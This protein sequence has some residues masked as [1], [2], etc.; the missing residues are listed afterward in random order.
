LSPTIITL[1]TLAIGA[2][3][4]LLAYLAGFPVPALTGPSII[5]CAVSLAG[6]KTDISMRVRDLSFVTIGIGM[7]T[8][9]TP[10]V[11]D[12]ARD[13][14]A[15]FVAL[16]ATLLLMFIT[17]IQIL[18]KFWRFDHVTAA[19]ASSPGH[20]SYVIGLSLGTKSD[21][22]TVAIVQSIRVF[23]L[24][25]LVPVVVMMM[26]YDTRSVGM[27]AQPMQLFDL[28]LSLIGAVAVGVVLMKLGVPAA[29]LLGGMGFSALSHLTGWISGDVP[30]WLALPAYMIL[31]CLIGTRFS[32]TKWGTLKHAMSAGVA[33]TLL[34]SFWT[35]AAAMV[36][37]Q[38]IDLSYPQV[39]IAFAPGGVETM[40]AMAI[41]LDA[42]PT[43]VAL[44]H[45]WRMVVLTF[46][47]PMIL[48]LPDRASKQ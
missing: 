33:V 17:C 5:I 11:V 23:I 46:A 42:D 36:V 9:V 6:L 1:R 31:G 16:T 14:P 22:S 13:W 41:I 47:A 27:S 21:T 38:F 15:S 3:G 28:S 37:T 8:Q 10:D 2:L 4:F 12:A 34:A 30:T 32:G 7:G 26:G 25:L 20:L 43:Y 29:M 45:I 48:A 40:A 39:L 44:H 19:L 24:T 18:K 35:V